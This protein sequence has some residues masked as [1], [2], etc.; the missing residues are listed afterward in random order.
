LLDSGSDSENSVDDYTLTDTA[1]N[2]EK[3]VEWH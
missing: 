2:D 1:V 3:E